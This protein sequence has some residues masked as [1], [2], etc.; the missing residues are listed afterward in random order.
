MVARNGVC[1]LCPLYDCDISDDNDDDSAVD[2][3]R[4]TSQFRLG[5]IG[6]VFT[7]TST[8]CT[9]RTSPLVNMSHKWLFDS[10]TISTNTSS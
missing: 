4:S 3:E 8:A 7:N 10:F 1:S 2:G 6:R 5:F 9:K